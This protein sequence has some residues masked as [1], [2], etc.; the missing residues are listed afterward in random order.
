VAQ[1]RH[2]L[3]FDLP[4]PLP[5]DPVP[6][7]DLV[8]R[9]GLTVGQPEPHRDHAGLTFGERAEDGLQLLLQQDETDRLTGLDGLGVLDQ[10]AE[11]AVAVLAQRYVQRHRLP[12]VILHLDE[13]LR[14]YVQFGRQLVRGRLPA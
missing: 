14:G 8:Q 7:A 9:L 4:Y 6:L 12:G 10:V 11:L 1:L 3:G 5:G 13:L 2:D